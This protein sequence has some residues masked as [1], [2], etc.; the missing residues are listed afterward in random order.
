MHCTVTRG[1]DKSV[2]AGPWRV[3]RQNYRGPPFAHAA[4]KRAEK[5]VRIVAW[6]SSW[7]LGTRRD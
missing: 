1:E 2:I 5:I 6:V 3:H 7:A 4:L